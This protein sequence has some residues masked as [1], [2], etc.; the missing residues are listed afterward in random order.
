MKRILITLAL[1][2]ALVLVA[3]SQM[4]CQPATEPATNNPPPAARETPPD[5]AAITTELTRIENDWPRVVKEKDVEAIRKVEADDYMG[6]VPDGSVSTKTMDIE[7]ATKGNMTVESIEVAD[8]KVTV[9][10]ADAAVASGRTII[11]GGKY[12][13]PDG[14]SMDITGEYRFV[15]TF[16]RRSGEWKLVASAAVRVMKPGPA[17][18]PTPKASPAVTAATPAT[19]AATPAVRSTPAPP[20]PRTTP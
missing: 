7:D 20:T 6:V 2:L 4:G 14:K 13:M 9:L 16:A 1:P 15:D 12:K 3:F 11:K 19:K 17:A 10:D 18:S 8:I 5:T